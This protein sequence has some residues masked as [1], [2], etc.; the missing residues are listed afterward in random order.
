MHVP[1]LLQE[2]IGGLALRAGITVLDGTING[3]GHSLEISR[4]IPGGCLIGLDRDSTILAK[5]RERL[6]NASCR[7]ILEQGN[8]RHLDQIL[9]AR[10]IISLDRCL[11]DLG[12]SSEQLAAS[13]RGFSF[14]IDEPL[15][16]SY[17]V[18]PVT[19]TARTIVNESAA[20]NLELML[21]EYGEE[22]FAVRI[23]QAI[24]EARKK[25]KIETTKEL[26][27]IIQEAVPRW[28]RS[29]RRRKHFATQTFQALR[30]AVNDE[31]RALAE[32]LNLAWHYLAPGGRLAVIS[33]HSG[34][35]RIVKKIFPGHRKIKPTWAEIKNNPR[36]RSAVLRLVQ[37]S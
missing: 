14:L 35:A 23:A 8:F 20:A 13:G 33:F 19:V 11:F 21:K 7:V 34:E 2:V 29:P 4:R 17:E 30:I 5:A 15:I 10:Q 32:G 27:A 3:A 16:M 18:E 31:F 1:V 24:V 37:K 12:V 9:N 25:K 28:Y 26:V 6:Q 22:P 36:A